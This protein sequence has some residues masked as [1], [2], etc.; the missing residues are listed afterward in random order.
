MQSVN[1]VRVG[2][3][4]VGV[5]GEIH[6]RNVARCGGAVLSRVF[7]ADRARAE[8]IAGALGATACSDPADLIV[9]VDAVLIASTDTTHAPLLLECIAAG[10]RVLCEK[11]LAMTL[12]DARQVLDAERS[13]GRPLIQLGFMREF[14]PAHAA[15][16]TEVESGRL[17]RPVLFRGTHVNP[18]VAPFRMTDE[19]AVVKS[20]IHDIHSTRFLTGYEFVE[21]MARSVPA[22]D[23]PQF[24]RLVTVSA[25][26]TNDAVALLDVNMNATYG[27]EVTAEVVCASGTA[28]TGLPTAAHVASAGLRS[29]GVPMHWGSR[30]AEAYRLEVDAWIRS[31]DNGQVVGPTTAD[32]VAAQQVADACCRS[33]RS[34]RNEPVG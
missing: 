11:P 12:N 17:G 24:T 25:K 14:D 10:K 16:R 32:G 1:P 7:D 13:H 22:D 9:S 19:E 8:A 33:L 15:V 4:G 21:V 26:L 28:R 31:V 27:Y 23:D 6:A 2:V 20:M 30:F 3:L 18:D 29:T 5:M 34:G